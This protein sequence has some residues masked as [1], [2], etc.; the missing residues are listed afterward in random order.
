MRAWPPKTRNYFFQMKPEEGLRAKCDGI[1]FTFEVK[2]KLEKP[3]MQK[4]GFVSADGSS[5]N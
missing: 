1:Y 5:S 3:D 2:S 4:W